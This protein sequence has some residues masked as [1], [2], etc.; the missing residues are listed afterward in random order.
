MDDLSVHLRGRIT[1][2]KHIS[3]A[4]PLCSDKASLQN[5]IYNCS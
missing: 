5:S 2:A 4:I 1:M 3:G